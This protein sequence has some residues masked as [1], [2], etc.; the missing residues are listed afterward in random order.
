MPEGD[1]AERVMVAARQQL[2]LVLV[3]TRQARGEIMITTHV[4]GTDGTIYL[5]TQRGKTSEEIAEAL[6]PYVGHFA[7]FYPPNMYGYINAQ[8]A[9]WGWIRKV[10][11]TQVTAEVPRTGYIGVVDAGEA[12][13]SYCTR[14]EPRR[15]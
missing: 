12:F 15:A 6:K 10:D 8:R 3:V 4:A 5:R 7:A 13:G 1:Q 14:I 9:T 11:G 2:S